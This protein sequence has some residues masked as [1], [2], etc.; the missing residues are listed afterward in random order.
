MLR[1]LAA[2]GLVGVVFTFVLALGQE[3]RQPFKLTIIH[4]N[5]NHANHEPQPSGDGGDARQAAVIKQIRA[6]TA[7]HLTVDAGD[8]FT[9]T[10]F[11]TEYKGLDN[12]PFLNELGF[13]AIAIGNHEFDEGDEGLA[14][15]A[16]KL[17]CPVLAANVDVSKSQVLKGKIKPYT[18]VQVS[19][20]DIGIIGLATTDTKTGSRPSQAI[21]FDGDYAKVVQTHVDMLTMK[22]VNK[23]IVL[24]HIGLSEDL[25][26]AGQVQGVDAIVGGH[27]HTLLSKTYREAKNTYPMKVNG[28]DGQP[29]YVV[30]AGGG[31]NRFVGR[32]ELEFDADGVVTKAGGDCILLSKFI[33][34]DPATAEIL[35]KLAAPLDAMKKKP[36]LD[37]SGK[38]ALLKI[39]LPSDKVREEETLLGDFVTD[40]MR[41]KAKT[42]VA[43]QGGGG[44]RAGLPQGEVTVGQ[45]FS[46]MP[47]TNKLNKFSLKG[48]DLLAALEHGVSRYGESG[49][50]RFLQIS[51]LRITVDPKRKKGERI[52]SAEVQ[53]ADRV[54]KPIDPMAIYSVASDNYIRT[55]G[56]DFAMLR[57]KAFDTDE[58]LSPVQDVLIDALKEN[59]P[60]DVKLD[61]RITILK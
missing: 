1:K 47:F 54:W 51:G 10:L 15:F 55:G 20:Q 4:T 52:V 39:D 48:A 57:D 42:Q 36:V 44:L 25:K 49:S 37:A 2:L 24:S 34:P 58:D 40:A 31:D 29:V 43:L 41:K 32:L 21:G 59:S 61:G 19:G 9:G 7:N 16:G 23:I 46:V 45:I 30:Q 14:A 12:V 56:D 26:L 18:I 22:G 13:Q 60:V 38:P 8:R 17:R 11:H 27:S 28:K 3:K 33:T 53:S 50:G 35:K 6:E 5:D